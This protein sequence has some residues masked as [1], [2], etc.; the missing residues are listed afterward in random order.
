MNQD[1]ALGAFVGLAIGDAL[2]TTLEFQ[3][4]PTTDRRTWHTEMTGGGA[5]SVPP[6]GWTD[7]TSMALALA[8][9]LCV[10]GKFVPEQV[11]DNFVVWWLDGKF[12]WANKC[13]DIGNATRDA[14]NRQMRRKPG[15]DPYLGSTHVSDSGNGGIMRL[16]PTVIANHRNLAKAIEDSINQSRVTHASDECC[17]FANLLAR[18][19]YAGDPFIDEVSQHILAD[20]TAWLDLKTWGYVRHTFHAAMWAA[21]NSDSFEECLLLAVNLKGDAD[22]IGAVAGQIAGAMYGYQAIPERWL[23]QLVWHDKMVT[24]ANR[25]YELGSSEIVDN[26]AADKSALEASSLAQ[27]PKEY[28]EPKQVSLSAITVGSIGGISGSFCLTLDEHVIDKPIGFWVNA[29]GGVEL[30][31]PMLQQS[32]DVTE[33]VPAIVLTKS[34]LNAAQALITTFLPAIQPCGSD[35]T[36]GACKPNHGLAKRTLPQDFV[37]FHERLRAKPVLRKDV[38]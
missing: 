27:E 5:F 11:A 2:G 17:L 28:P 19:I 25:L 15:D 14:L 21:R 12:S 7:D 24:M 20:D 30:E 33:Q 4:G 22:T 1:Q 31:L 35:S 8:D 3:S 29:D 34:T 13:I 32:L 26:S 38:S 36:S 23:N 10:S 6:G 18:V 9:S 16:A 37:L